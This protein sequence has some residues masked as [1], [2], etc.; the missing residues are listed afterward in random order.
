MAI[1]G[2]NAKFFALILAVFATG[3]TAQTETPDYKPSI[4]EAAL[5]PKFCWKQFMGKKF[6][7]P[8]FDIPRRSCGAYVNHYCPGLID[9]NRAQRA[10]GN[11]RKRRA[12]LKRAR[13]NTLY[14]LKGIRSYP[15]CPIRAHAEATLRVIDALQKAYR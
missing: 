7:G 5:L 2:N 14:T 6:S 1:V 4:S 12:D 15:N 9:L 11:E 8:Q 10:I 13:D 3:A